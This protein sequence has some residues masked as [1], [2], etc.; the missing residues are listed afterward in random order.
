MSPA[1]PSPMLSQD[2]VQA[3]FLQCGALLDGH[4]LLSSGLHS[5]SYLQCA[6]VLEAPA[7]AELLGKE[8]G[9]RLRATG[10]KAEAVLS[11]ALGGVIIGH[12]VARALGVR[13]LFTER[14]AG[15]RAVL[16]RGFSLRPGERIVVVEDVVTTGGSTKEV[17]EVAKAAGA[18]VQAVAAIVDRSGGQAPFDVPFVS[19][20]QL[21]VPAYPPTHCPLCAQGTPAIKPGSRK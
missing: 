4:F 10:S 20:L 15:G 6:L 8:L 13:C 11:P 2:D 9:D 19:L 21:N 17:M 12:E 5:P 16:R 14:D 18:V 3:L 1:A 7:R